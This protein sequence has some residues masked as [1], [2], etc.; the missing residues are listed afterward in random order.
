MFSFELAQMY[1]NVLQLSHFY[2]VYCFK[3]TVY[4]TEWSHILVALQNLD[5]LQKETHLVWISH[6]CE[7][8]SLSH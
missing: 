6:T 7:V 4:H 3:A 1:Q 5:E 8:H 2:P